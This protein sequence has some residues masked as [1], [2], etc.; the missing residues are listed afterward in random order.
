MPPY[1]RQHRD[2]LKSTQTAQ[3]SA[4]NGRAKSPSLNRKTQERPGCKRWAGLHLSRL[5]RRLP[6]GAV[7]STRAGGVFWKD[8]L[9]RG[10]LLLSVQMR[11]NRG[12]CRSPAPGSMLQ[13][14]GHQHQEPTASPSPSVLFLQLH[15]GLNC[16]GV[17]FPI[18]RLRK[19]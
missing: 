13:A 5:A 18:K 7:L 8:E 9:G 4:A 10:W 11:R 1:L 19:E 12:Q 2:M 3:R 16:V 14:R 17:F 6:L 15:V